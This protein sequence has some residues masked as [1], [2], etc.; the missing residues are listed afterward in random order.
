MLQLSIKRFLYQHSFYS[1]E[2][3]YEHT[4]HKDM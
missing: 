4:D 1:I 2:E 3:Y